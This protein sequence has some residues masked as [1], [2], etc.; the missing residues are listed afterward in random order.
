MTPSN[1]LNKMVKMSFLKDYQVITIN[2]GIN[3][4]KFEKTEQKTGIKK[5]NKKRSFGCRKYMGEKKRT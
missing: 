4:E 1:W 2:N 5:G 3:L